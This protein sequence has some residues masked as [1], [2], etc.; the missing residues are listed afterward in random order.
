MSE[1]NFN[2]T[3]LKPDTQYSLAELNTLVMVPGKP[4]AIKA[5]SD[6]DLAEGKAAAYAEQHG[7]YIQPLPLDPPGGATGPSTGIK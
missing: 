2:I 7:G 4:S 6:T 1:S 3:R 5:F